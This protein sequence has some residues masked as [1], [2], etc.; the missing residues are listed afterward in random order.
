[1]AALGNL[2][3]WPRAR[4]GAAR[5][6]FGAHF[7]RH[8]AA[9]TPDGRHAVIFTAHGKPFAVEKPRL[10]RDVAARWFDPTTGGLTRIEPNPFRETSQP[11]FERR[12]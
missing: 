7:R 9:I 10:N 11:R 1:M 3:L 6:R 12:V 2:A 4:Q 8:S 5:G